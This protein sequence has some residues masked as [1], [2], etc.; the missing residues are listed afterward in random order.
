MFKRFRQCI[1]MLL[2]PALI[3]CIFTAQFAGCTSTEPDENATTKA[4]GS[5]SENSARSSETVT[6]PNMA[7]SGS[8]EDVDAVNLDGGGFTVDWHEEADLTDNLT[9]PE[10]ELPVRY[11]QTDEYLFAVYEDYVAVCL[12]LGDDTSVTIPS[13]YDGL[14]VTRI[15]DPKPG[16][17]EFTWYEPFWATDIEEVI[18]PDGVT[19]IG[20][21]SFADCVNLTSVVIPDSV[22]AIGLAAFRDT[23]WYETLS[24]EFVIVG[25]SCLI[26]YN[27]TDTVVAIPDGV[28]NICGAFEGN[29]TLT[30]VSIPDTV[31]Q[32]TSSAF[33]ACTALVEITIPDSV[34]LLGNSAF[35]GCKALTAVNGGTAVTEIDRYAFYG[36]FSL[37]SV[38]FE[39]SLAEIGYCAFYCCTSLTEVDFPDSL[40][41]IGDQ[42]FQGCTALVAVKNG[43][44]VIAVGSLAFDATP[45]FEAL[46]D[47]YVVVGKNVL[48]GYNGSDKELV[49]PDTIT[50]IGGAFSF[51]SEVYQLTKIVIPGSVRGICANCFNMQK[52]LASITIEGEGVAL[53]NSSLG[54]DSL[55]EV[56]IPSDT[57]VLPYH[58]LAWSNFTEF[59]IPDSVVIVGEGAFLSCSYLTEIEIP[60]SCIAIESQAFYYCEKLTDVTILNSD[61]YIG[62]GVFEGCAEN[63]TIHGYEG[64][65]AE[66]YAEEYGIAFEAIS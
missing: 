36:C 6:D 53:G 65:T 29:E 14:P 50:Y 21:L 25:D 24:D 30:S 45:W 43:K 19:E 9:L 2:I 51:D 26:R 15:G 48:I 17:G 59:D 33:S 18:I 35:A 23:P 63:L 57:V 44:N 7:V 56:T 61:A 60:E 62:E 3:L 42:A 12:Y 10:M 16:C 34:T 39:E 8:A 1:R 20:R 55:T 58:A 54:C 46:E 52:S 49:I 32:I 40:H 38:S 5:D 11:A 41:I 66:K 27:G 37:T 64:S 22:T 31:T 13:E 4:A 47:Y 28:K